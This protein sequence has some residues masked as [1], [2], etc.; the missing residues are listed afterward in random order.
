MPSWQQRIWLRPFNVLPNSPAKSFDL[1]LN[2][3]DGDGLELASRLRA[4]TE[5]PLVCVMSSPAWL[6][7]HDKQMELI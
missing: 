6:G 3:P 7:E 1:I 2:L 4:S 5:T